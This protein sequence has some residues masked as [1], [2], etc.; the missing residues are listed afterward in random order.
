MTTL[1][2][3]GE[4]TDNFHQEISFKHVDDLNFSVFILWILEY[5]LDCNNLPS[6]LDFSFVNLAKGALSDNFEQVDVIGVKHGRGAIHGSFGMHSCFHVEVEIV[7]RFFFGYDILFSSF[8]VTFIFWKD[9]DHFLFLFFGWL[10]GRIC[11]PL[12]DW[13]RLCEGFLVEIR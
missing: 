3:S 6:F 11:W 10:Y 9:K 13:P 4:S 8:I 2:K 5:F 12:D 1:F 7:F